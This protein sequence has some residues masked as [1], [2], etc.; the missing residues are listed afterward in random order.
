MAE[1]GAAS[2]TGET[3]GEPTRGL[4]VVGVDGSQ[5]SIA[6]LRYAGRLAEG[7]GCTIEAVA[8]WQYHMALGTF[9][10][11]DWTPEED[12]RELLDQ[13]VREAFGSDPPAG[14]RRTVRQGH[15]ASVLAEA[16]AG[17]EMLIV[18]SRGHGGIAGMLLG[19]VS[20]SVSAHARCPV[21]VM[22][23]QSAP[24]E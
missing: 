15:A 4:I 18:G 20:Y 2:T 1:T 10:P 7:L 23:Q 12:T 8:A 11:L 9:T 21:L 16:G 5:L 14:L 6:A 24:E 22:H 17:A 13:A 3:S 19:S